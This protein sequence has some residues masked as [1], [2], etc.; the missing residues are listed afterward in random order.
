MILHSMKH[1][2]VLMVA[3]LLAMVACTNEP[4][5]SIDRTDLQM[6]YKGGRCEF[7]VSSN[8]EWEIFCNSDNEDLLTI[9]QTEGPSGEQ[10]IQVIVNKN[11]SKSILNHYFTAVAH[12]KKRDALAYFTITQGAPAYVVFSKNVFTTDYI[13]GEYEFTVSSNFPWS[14]SVKGAGITVDPMSGTPKTKADGDDDEEEEDENS[15]KITVTIDEYE[16][17]VNRDFELT[18]TA[19][20]DDTVVSDKLVITQNRPMLVIGKREYPIKKMG[21]G[22]WWMV[23]NLCYSTKGVSIG[24]GVCGIWYPC[25]DTALDFDSSEAGIIGKGLLYSDATAFDTNITATTAKRMENTPQGICPDGW[26]IPKLNEYLALVGKSTNTE[27]EVNTEAPYYDAARNHGSLSMLEEAGFNTTM[28]GY[29]Q[30]KSKGFEA[31]GD[32]QGYL[33]SRGYI[34]TSYL[35]CST[36][37]SSTM[38]YALVLNR[39]ANTADVGMMSNFTTSRPFAG[40]VRCIKDE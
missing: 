19:I 6:D 30:G 5:I 2:S 7:N 34:T 31:N 9:S 17:D 32:I 35:F 10:N 25:S 8:C 36:A 4:E 37:Y 11:D 33:A 39:T 23:Q 14:I 22:R 26:H 15:S 27:I 21:D 16:G 38:W 40:S 13:G 20:G 18:V 28:S 24:D 29:V 1:F 3:A 12:G